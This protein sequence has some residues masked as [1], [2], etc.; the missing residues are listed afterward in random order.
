M[1]TPKEYKIGYKLFEQREDG[2]IFPLFIGKTT[3]TR[4]GE[5]IRAENIPTHG[6]ATR[7]GWHC[8]MTIPDAPHLRG[9]DGSSLGPYKSRF[10]N[11][12]RVWCEVL[13][14]TT[15]DYREE[16]SKLP[17]KCFTDKLPTNGWYLFNEG[18]RSTWAIS[19][20]IKVTRIL[21]ENERQQILNA[22]NYDEVAAFAP[23]KEAFEKRMKNCTNIQN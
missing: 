3:E 6:Y 21:S 17:R 22:M 13:Y 12:K 5:W 11:G 1:I 2:K 14:N 23:Y 8:S 20:T 15:V 7:P 16:V 19:D 4:I 9:Y 10:K 18:N